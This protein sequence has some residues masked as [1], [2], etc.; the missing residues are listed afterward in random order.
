MEPVP[1]DEEQAE[2]LGEAMAVLIECGAVRV[3][4]LNFLRQCGR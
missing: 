3:E 2:N 1:V 4:Q